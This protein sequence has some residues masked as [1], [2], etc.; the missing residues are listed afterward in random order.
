MQNNGRKDGAFRACKSTEESKGKFM[1]FGVYQ[2]K[3]GAIIY[4]PLKGSTITFI[5]VKLDYPM[6]L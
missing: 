3:D 6:S 2:V 4:D 5:G 1:D